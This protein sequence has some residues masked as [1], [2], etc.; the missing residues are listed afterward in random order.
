MG[1]RSVQI[2]SND[3]QQ[4]PDGTWFDN[5]RGVPFAWPQFAY[6]QVAEQARVIDIGALKVVDFH[7]E[8]F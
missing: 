1:R 7:V 5:Q 6:A 3:Y 8:R 4:K 2:G